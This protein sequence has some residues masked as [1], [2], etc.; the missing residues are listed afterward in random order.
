MK[1]LTVNKSSTGAELGLQ[2]G[3]KIE[4]IDGS[5]VKDIIDYRFK[6]S[7]E[8]IVLRVRQ[9]GS[10]Q[11]YEIEKDY[12]DDLGLEFEDFR[13]RNCA[14]DCIFCF[15]DQN[16]PGMRDAL[17]FRD[18]DFRLSFLH[19]HYITMTNMGWKEL[20]RVVE[21]RLSP[22][23]VS[24]HVTQPDK[25]L[26]M[27]L[28]G[29][30]DLLLKKFEYLTENGIELHSQVVLCPSW[31][32]GEFLEQTIKDIHQYAPIA[33][34][35]SI[36]PAGLTKHR[37]GLP[38]IAPVTVDYAKEFVP[39]AESLADKYR[40]ADDRRFVFLSDEW[41]LMTNTSLPKTAYYEDSDLSENGV[42]QVPHFW[43]NWQKEIALLPQKIDTPKRV[44]VCTGTL[45]SDW[46]KSNW[47]PTVEKI[48]NLEVN[49][50][51][52]LNEFYGSKEVTVSGL[53][54]GKDI[55]DQLKEKDLGDMVIF[56][57]RILSETGTVTLDDMSLDRISK[58]VGSPVVVTD[59]TPLSFFNLLK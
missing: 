2:P 29:K 11:E 52:I 22:L 59:D 49:H 5:R 8:N 20:K 26:E 21:Q 41:F 36:V 42:G 48:E 9:S 56:S 53:L 43:E 57:D 34:S 18:G 30:D 55:I 7:D 16:P 4:A 31:N 35:M 6:V 24:V 33:R 51:T 39:F 10:I 25:R 40:L 32:D 17:Y 38:Y 3:D 50:L 58:E 54:V 28:Y 44:T 45:I 14:N 23:Y 19:G 46:F 27:F 12:D 15:V 13:I 1:I 47:M 37:D